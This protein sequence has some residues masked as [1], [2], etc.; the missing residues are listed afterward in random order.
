MSAR[1]VPAVLSPEDKTDAKPLPRIRL[2]LGSSRAVHLPSPGGL[3]HP[4]AAE[5][6]ILAFRPLCRTASDSAPLG[7]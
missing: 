5:A 2:R 7:R 6:L 4:R 1:A 3:A